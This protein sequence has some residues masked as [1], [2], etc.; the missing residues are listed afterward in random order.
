MIRLLC[1]VVVIVILAGGVPQSSAQSPSTPSSSQGLLEEADG[2]TGG[3]ST[4]RVLVGPR[5]DQPPYAV[6][7]QV[8]DQP[9]H[10]VAGQAA[11]VRH[12]APR[13]PHGVTDHE[14]Q[15]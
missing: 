7:R 5:A 13:V 4:V 12:D 2:G 11:G 9:Q 3:Q 8:F 6:L 10:R 1:I 14:R 15:P